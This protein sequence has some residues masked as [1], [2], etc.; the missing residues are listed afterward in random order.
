MINFVILT[1]TRQQKEKHILKEFDNQDIL[2]I[3][4]NLPSADYMALRYNSKNGMYLDY[5]T[6]ID[7]KKNLL[8]ICNNLCRSSEHER[9]IR[10][11][12]LGQKLGC[13]KFIFLIGEDEINSADDIKKWQSKYTKVTGEKLLKIMVT[14][15]KHHNCNFIFVSKEKMGEKIIEILSNK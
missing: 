13:K 11:V 10:E 8:E 9:L 12:E 15:S 7:T 4:T 2:H 6:L 3:R 14:F 1:D 5:S